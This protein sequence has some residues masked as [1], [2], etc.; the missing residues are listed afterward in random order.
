MTGPELR[1]ARESLSL[2]G[3]D[4]ALK[5]LELAQLI[6]RGDA[7]RTVRNW[8]T[9]TTPVDPAVALLIELMLTVPAVR[10]RLGVAL[11]G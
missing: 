5:Q 8:E 3:A 10:K 4:H 1:A 6:G 9:G 11:V 2:R 7:E